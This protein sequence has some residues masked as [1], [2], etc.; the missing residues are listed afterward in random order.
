MK[1]AWS[2]LIIALINGSVQIGII[3][4]NG[5]SIELTADKEIGLVKALVFFPLTHGKLRKS[6]ANELIKHIPD[7]TRKWKI[8]SW[9]TVFNI[10]IPLIGSVV[11]NNSLTWKTSVHVTL[12]SFWNSSCSWTGLTKHCCFPVRRA[13]VTWKRGWKALG[14]VSSILFM[15]ILFGINI[16]N[17]TLHSSKSI[18]AL[19]TM[20]RTTNFLGKKHKKSSMETHHN[21]R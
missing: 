14:I 4:L 15:D 2:Q 16:V 17:K 13:G 21:C 7:F 1:S 5:H 19:D 10:W 18:Q 20:F 3:K 9:A 6:S 12:W 8:T 11:R